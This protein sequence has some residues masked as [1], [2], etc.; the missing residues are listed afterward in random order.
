M[1]IQLKVSNSLISLVNQL[2][3]E[4]SHTAPVFE[5]VYIVTQTEG[6]NNWL[7][8][9]LAEKLGIAA[10]IH[11]LKPN[12]AIQLIYQA[13]GG[14]HRQTLSSG[15]MPWLLY[16]ALNE[17]IF[18]HK[19]PD[20]A[21]Y[22]AHKEV[23]ARQKR[24]ALAVK[25][26]DLMDQYQ[27]YRTDIIEQWDAG[28]GG[29][30]W[31]KWLWRYIRDIAGN[32]FP[33][34]T[35]VG[36]YIIEALQDRSKS[37]NLRH[38][39][40]AIYFFGL[41]LITEYHVQLIHFI[42]QHIEIRFLIQ[43][44]A[45][46]QYWLEDMSQKYISHMQ[47]KGRLP[48]DEKSIANP[49][50]VGWGKLIQDTFYLLFKDEENYNI[51]DDSGIKEPL[52][53]TL[54]HKI[55]HAIYHN[56]NEKKHFSSDIINDG[57]ITINSNYSPLRE[58]EVLYNYLV[59]CVD[60]HPNQL[61]ARDIVVMVSDIDTYASYIRAV[62]DNAPYSFRYTIADESYAVSDSITNTLHALLAIH[63]EEFTSEKVVSLLD[64]SSIRNQFQITDI[65]S[66]RRWTDAANIRFG[67]KGNSEDET[68]YVS[69][70]YGLNRLMYG[71]CMSGSEEFITGDSSFY[72]VDITEGRDSLEVVRFTHFVQSLQHFIRNRQGEKT[73]D[74]WVAYVHEVI[75]EFIG[76][77]EDNDQEDFRILQQQLGK[78]SLVSG[79]FTGKVPF[80][81]F[82][83]QLLPLLS[84]N[85][86]SH[87]YASHGIT[88][89][90]LIP[91]RSIPFRVVALLGMN[92]DKF[93]RKD[94][95]VSFD[96]MLKNPRRGD[97]N[98]KENDK[99]LLLETLLSAGD[100]LYISY[101]G[102]SVRDNSHLPP[103][104]LIDELIDY[105]ASHSSEPDEVRKNFVQRHSLHSYSRKYNAGNPRL[106]SYMSD[107]KASELSLSG[108]ADI[109]VQEMDEITF[110]QL[111]SFFRNPVK[112]FYNKVLNVYLDETDMDL[113]ETEIFELDH[114]QKWSLRNALLSIDNAEYDKFRLQGVKKGILTL[115]NS[116]V[117]AIDK[118]LEEIQYVKDMMGRI[119]AGHNNECYSLKLTIGDTILTGVIDNIFGDK[120]VQYSFSKSYAKY[121]F[122]AYLTALVLAAA[123]HPAQVIYIN[124]TEKKMYSVTKLSR[125]EAILR[126][127]RLIAIYTEGHRN[128]LPFSFE[129]EADKS[130]H[131]DVDWYNKSIHKYFN[132]N[133]DDKIDI[134]LK[135]A[136]ERETFNHSDAYE[137]CKGVAEATWKMIK[138]CLHEILF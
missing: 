58:V 45:P 90:S 115:K 80:E 67:Y 91:M 131:F 50:L 11:F 1:A 87:N 66:I 70:E 42:A 114:L 3:G 138:S 118:N 104:S 127:Q 43:N 10:N 68:I 39:I 122:Q 101:L 7:R 54:L 57:S 88:F 76:D 125:D 2:A 124:N 51:Y 65:T 130:G 63:A 133:S 107:K 121:Q 27:I 33:D 30:D 106:Y 26:A 74:E 79:I 85:R 15:D 111:I 89:C 40:P 103:S 108:T 81:V 35:K 64:Y 24:M 86:R 128:I 120:V 116:G 38:K 96:L 113:H 99:H 25:M 97:R 126:L 72:P 135:Y 59:K 94:Q 82:I 119:A 93:P 56:S 29:D 49:L 20:I 8:I 46:E 134:Y 112:A 31:Q 75:A 18:I 37:E 17:K 4:L 60:A 71:I 83:Y 110:S 109:P 132:S 47:R 98:L 102:Q 69:W 16:Q 61:S 100:Y 92:F 73:L 77:T 34:K 5:P 62:F 117:V 23:N 129:F 48:K 78:Y 41:S 52:Q 136:N 28:E 22:Y 44:P 123:D 137:Q 19:F 13:T 32:Q 36:K 53:D 12:D 55:Q 9:Q 21:S 6:M 105:I 95:R 14:K 84:S